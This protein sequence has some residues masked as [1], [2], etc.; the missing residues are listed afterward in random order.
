MTAYVGI[1]LHRRRSLAVCLDEEGEGLWWRRFENSLLTMA[2]VTIPLLRPPLRW[3]ALAVH[4]TAAPWPGWV[5]DALQALSQLSIA[6][7]SV[8]IPNTTLDKNHPLRDAICA[9]SSG[10]SV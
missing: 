1:D 8:R 2:E 7:H 10:H 3:S 4:C 6:P 5:C 9:G